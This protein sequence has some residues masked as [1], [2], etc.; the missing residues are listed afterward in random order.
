MRTAKHIVTLMEWNTLNNNV[1]LNYWDL[2]VLVYSS[3]Q[4][5]CQK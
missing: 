2:P 4:L 1:R 5:S 3:S